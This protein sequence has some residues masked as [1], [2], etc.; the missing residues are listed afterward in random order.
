MSLTE[1]MKLFKPRLESKSSVPPGMM[2]TQRV[3]QT[4]RPIRRPSYTNWD[5]SK[6]ASWL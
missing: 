1:L 5:S 3:F 2:S 4:L 6:P